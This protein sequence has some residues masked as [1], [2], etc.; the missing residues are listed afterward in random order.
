MSDEI[1]S[2]LCDSH[3]PE[4]WTGTIVCAKCERVYRIEHELFPPLT[5]EDRPAP[6]RCVCG[7]P[8][9]KKSARMICSRCYKDR[10]EKPS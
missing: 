2:V 4:T 3:G 8:L 5:K 9:I 7:V 10:L 6:K 1:F